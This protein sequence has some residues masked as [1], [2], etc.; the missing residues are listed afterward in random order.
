MGIRGAIFNFVKG[1]WKSPDY[2][3]VLH[4]LPRAG[5]VCLGSGWGCFNSRGM[6]EPQGILV[7]HVGPLFQERIDVGQASPLPAGGT[8]EHQGQRAHLRVAVISLLPQALFVSISEP[9]LGGRGGG[10]RK[11]GGRVSQKVGNFHT[12]PF[13]GSPTLLHNIVT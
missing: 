1:K 7:V 2:P 6:Q 11:E 3:C 9:E 5:Q 12:L 10:K 8:G 4:H 13:R